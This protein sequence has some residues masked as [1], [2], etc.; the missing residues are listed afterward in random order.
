MLQS[1]SF[2]SYLITMLLQEESGSIFCVLPSVIDCNK[3]STSP[4]LSS[5]LN[6][7]NSLRL[8]LYVT[9]CSSH[10]TILLTPQHPSCTGYP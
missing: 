5:R 7:S 4:L 10:L 2:A 3:V 8:Y 9:L 6:N 1:V